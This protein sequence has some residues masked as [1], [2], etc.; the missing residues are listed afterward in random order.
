MN[1]AQQVYANV[2]LKTPSGQS[3]LDKSATA[4]LIDELRP[5]SMAVAKATAWL[6]QTGFRVD[7]SG[8]TLSVSG[9]QSQFEAVFGMHLT[10]YQQDGQTYYRIDKPAT[11]PAPMRA[12]I[13]AIM[14]AEPTQYFN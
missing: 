8:I 3:V 5:D 1:P 13:Q 4:V 12:I 2:V 11:I 6:E 14:P 10:A 7:Q 9:P